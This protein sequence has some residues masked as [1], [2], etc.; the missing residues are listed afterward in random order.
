VRVVDVC[1]DPEQLAIQV[2]A[3]ENVVFRKVVGPCWE[4]GWIIEKVLSPSENKVD[5]DRCS[6]FN[7]LAIGIYPCVVEPAGTETFDSLVSACA[8]ARGSSL[9]EGLQPSLDTAQAYRVLI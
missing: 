9:T 1:E 8:A 5:V 6:K 4:R 2:L 3:S 7:W